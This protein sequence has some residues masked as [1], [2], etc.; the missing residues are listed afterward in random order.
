[1]KRLNIKR[2]Q[3]LSILK[4]ALEVLL[5]GLGGV[6]SVLNQA[7]L[8]PYTLF[9]LIFPKSLKKNQSHPVSKFLRTQLEKKT[10][11]RK[12]GLGVTGLVLLANIMV[13]PTSALDMTNAPDAVLPL[14]EETV[15]TETIFAKPLEGRLCQGFHRWHPAIDICA[16]VGTPIHSIAAGEVVEATYSRLGWGNT[17]VV[18][19]T[20]KGQEYWSRYAHLDKILVKV[21]Q[22]LD[23]ETIVGTIGMTGW[24]TGPHLHLELRLSNGQAL[25]PLEYLPTLNYQLAY[26]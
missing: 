7:L 19:H 10:L 15:V 23:R 5:Q 8:V 4:P 9:R 12:L 3:I 6:K 16:P 24:T 22:N 1:M 18:K 25:N 14:P 21:G 20:L 11:Q 2:K 13:K 26:K 17:I